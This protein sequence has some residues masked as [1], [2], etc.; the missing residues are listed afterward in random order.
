MNASLEK[1]AT[2]GQCVTTQKDRFNAGAAVVMRAM[3][4]IAKVPK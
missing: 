3:E 1:R 4:P 2:V